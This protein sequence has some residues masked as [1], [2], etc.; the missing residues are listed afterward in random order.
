MR[1]E[2]AALLAVVAIWAAAFP[3]IKIGVESIGV[4]EVALWRHVAACSL[5]VVY[6]LITKTP[7]RIERQDWW[8]FAIVSFSM[9][10]LYHLGLNYGETR[11]SAGAA[12]LIVSMAP[13]LVAVIAPFALKERFTLN[14]GLGIFLA[15]GGVG[16]VIVSESSGFE[17]K[18]LLGFI[19]TFAAPL[20]AAY[21]TLASKRLLAR[22]GA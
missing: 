18:H 19:A 4:F 11:I 22:Y 20:S 1:R 12:S 2:E 10:P 9:V 8:T 5:L 14:R 17:V 16:F 15:F 21:N 7:W 3:A 6:L 13:L